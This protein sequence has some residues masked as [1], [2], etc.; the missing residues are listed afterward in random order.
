[1][2]GRLHQPGHQARAHHSL[3]P[4]EQWCVHRQIKDDLRAHG[5]GPMWHSHLP[6]V[7]M[8]LHAVSKEDSAV[9][10]A[11]LVNGSPLRDTKLC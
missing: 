6:R 8:G 10:S 1:V 3:P 7:L 4:S 5:A 9:S 11:E 2:H